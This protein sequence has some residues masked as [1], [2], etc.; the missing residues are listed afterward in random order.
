[1]DSFDKGTLLEE[2]RELPLQT[3][4]DKET[5]EYHSMSAVQAARFLSICA[6]LR[7]GGA[8]IHRKYTQGFEANTSRVKRRRHVSDRDAGSRTGMWDWAH[9]SDEELP[10]EISTR[11]RKSKGAC[12]RDQG[13]S[14]DRSDA[15]AGQHKVFD[16]SIDDTEPDT[17]N[18]VRVQ[19][20]ATKKRPRCEI[21]SD[22]SDD[23]QDNVPSNNDEFVSH[24][25]E[26]PV[27]A[28]EQSVVLKDN[29]SSTCPSNGV[30]MSPNDKVEEVNNT[31][32]HNDADDDYCDEDFP[33]LSQASILPTQQDGCAIVHS[34]CIPVA[35]ALPSLASCSVPT[36]AVEQSASPSHAHSASMH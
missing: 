21:L 35:P 23:A 2:M 7:G 17:D 26:I 15:K 25:A 12:H 28:S 4:A 11:R 8:N 30:T 9:D 22:D 14:G 33:L 27:P 34:A 36:I 10:K 5:Q 3:N 32:I 13:A 16:L 18:E 19:R 20:S 1:M 31:A 24:C 29:L 6:K